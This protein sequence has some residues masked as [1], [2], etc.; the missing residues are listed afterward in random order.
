MGAPTLVRAS[1]CL[2]LT[3]SLRCKQS[4]SQPSWTPGKKDC[5][6]RAADGFI[7]TPWAQKFPSWTNDGNNLIAMVMFGSV[8]H[9]NHGSA[10]NNEVQHRTISQKHPETPFVVNLTAD[11]SNDNEF[12]ALGPVARLYE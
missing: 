3:Y 2:V 6:S 12:V 5:E 11:P 8:A 9:R 7:G 1:I 10:P 4:A